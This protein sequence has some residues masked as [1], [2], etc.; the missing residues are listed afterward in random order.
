MLQRSFPR[1]RALGFAAA[2]TAMPVAA[3]ASPEGWD[4]ASDVARY[5]LVAAALATPAVQEDWNGAL[6]AG[7]SIGV[8][9]GVTYGL[10]EAFPSW[11]PDRSDRESFPSG[12]TSTSFAAAATLQN[13]YGWKVGLPAHVVAA[14]AG[15][16]RVKADQ[17]HWYDVLAGAAIG[18]AAGLLITRKRNPNVQVF[19]WGDT[20]GGGIS[21]AMRF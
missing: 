14:F 13:R 10:K 5:A 19:P 8:A 12:H 20:K 15:V 2:F 18:E 16:A 4:D 9:Y 17:H 11:R 6:Q 21:M 3:H 7:A 1:C